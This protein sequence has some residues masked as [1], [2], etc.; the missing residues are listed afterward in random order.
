MVAQTVKNL[1]AV[2]ETRVQSLGREDPL[3][4]GTELTSAFLPGEFH[5]RRSLVSYSPWGCK[6]SDTAEQ[7]TF[8]TLTN[9][10]N[11]RLPNNALLEYNPPVV[12]YDHNNGVCIGKQSIHHSKYLFEFIRVEKGSG[13]LFFH[14]DLH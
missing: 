10:Q 9:K 1:P 3:E 2:Q 7:L 12:M 4:K 14:S 11:L 13:F 6:E 5:G 8:N